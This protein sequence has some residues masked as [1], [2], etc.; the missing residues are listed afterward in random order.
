MWCKDKYKIKSPNET[1][2]T[3]ICGFRV[4]IFVFSWFFLF[5]KGDQLSWITE[6]SKTVIF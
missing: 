4:L 1:N 2:E 5:I 3:T 6:D